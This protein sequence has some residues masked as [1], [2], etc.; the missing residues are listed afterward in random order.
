[1]LAT[2]EELAKL[3]LCDTIAFPGYPAFFDHNGDRPI[4]RVGAISSDPASDYRPDYNSIGRRI[5]YEAF[6][7]EGS[8]GS[9]VFALPKGLQLGPG[10]SGPG[11]RTAMLIGINS[12]HVLGRDE[13]IGQIHSGLSYCFKSTSILECIEK[14]G[15]QT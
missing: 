9:P 13:R 14:L 3:D 11:H 1:M 6:S 10:L 7:T 2:D 8:S 4:M 15:H 5:A 12:G